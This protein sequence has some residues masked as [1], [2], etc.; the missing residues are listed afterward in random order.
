MV[1][2]RFIK[3]GDKMRAAGSRRAGADRELAGELGLAGGGKGC[4]F[5]VA[6]A[7]PFYV[8]AADRVGKRVERVADQ[9][10]DMPDPELLE[11]V[12]ENVRNR[13]G[14][15]CL[16]FPL[17]PVWLLLVAEWLSAFDVG[18]RPIRAGGQLLVPP[19][20]GVLP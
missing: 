4:A 14:Q 20:V 3:A 15:L 5:L 2:A 10:E 8:A 16:L 13:L 7:D 9:S 1:A 19:A 6:D 12:D 18:F 17:G 11:R